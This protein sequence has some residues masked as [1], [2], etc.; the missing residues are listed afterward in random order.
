MVSIL[1]VSGK[2]SEPVPDSI[3]VIAFLCHYSLDNLVSCLHLALK[4][5]TVIPSKRHIHTL[6]VAPFAFEGEII[7]EMAQ[8]PVFN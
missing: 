6:P 1:D 4:I 2:P 5:T 7:Y 3:S 8:V